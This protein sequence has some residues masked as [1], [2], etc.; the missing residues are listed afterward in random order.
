M[1]ISKLLSPTL[2]R[3]HVLCPEFEN[4]LETYRGCC[5]LSLQHHKNIGIVLLCLSAL[6]ARSA[7]SLATANEALQ[8]CNLAIQRGNVTLD[9]V[10]QL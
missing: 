6:A 8:L 10:G 4:V 1:G 7:P 5:E 2:A 9:D 3:F